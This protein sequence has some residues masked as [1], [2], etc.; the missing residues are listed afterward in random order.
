MK[1]FETL[2][3]N[4]EADKEKML[5]AKAAR[6][7]KT[8][9]AE[10]ARFRK[11][12]L[13]KLISFI[14]ENPSE[15]L[16]S[17]PD[18]GGHGSIFC[19]SRAIEALA[20]LA[21]IP[22]ELEPRL[23]ASV[24]PEQSYKLCTSLFVKY[25]LNEG[26]IVTVHSAAELLAETMNRLRAS[27]QDSEH[28]LPCVFFLNGG[29]DE[30]SIGPVRF[31]RARKFF[32][33]NRARI[34]RS[35]QADIEASVAQ[36]VA[37]VAHEE[38]H[39]QKHRADEARRWVRILRA[40]AIKTYRIYP[41]VAQVMV[42]ACDK[43]TSKERAR[44]MVELALNVVRVLLGA[45]NSKRIRLAWANG[46]TVK[47][48]EMWSTDGET[49]GVRISSGSISPVGGENWHDLL[50]R[51]GGGTF[52]LL[53]E[54]TSARNATSFAQLGKRVI[55]SIHWFGDGAVDE[56]PTAQVIEIAP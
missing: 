6:C 19:G 42:S 35:V 46:K 48:A 53:S 28:F 10:V 41:W 29:P 47:T 4:V 54:L 25:F 37:I 34:S 17:I 11:F 9:A 14:D 2:G 45:S 12:P 27:L 44:E 20:N 32:R 26:R 24:S 55:D 52:E 13:K 39:V 56:E 51:E 36:S 30:F 49:I 40:R 21:R 50:I 15:A 16:C 31:T 1:S 8:A 23:D 5:A 33:D 22:L 38:T 18:D 43:N 7:L 3:A